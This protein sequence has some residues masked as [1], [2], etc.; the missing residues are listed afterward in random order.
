MRL[1]QNKLHKQ[2]NCEHTMKAFTLRWQGKPVVRASLITTSAC[3]RIELWLTR[4]ADLVG[5]GPHQ[6]LVLSCD[7][8]MGVEKR[9]AQY[10]SPA[11][12]PTSHESLVVVALDRGHSRVA[13]S[14]RLT[15]EGGYPGR[16]KL[17]F[18]SSHGARTH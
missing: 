8:R 1:R 3:R 7:V 9:S 11:T 5:G 17:F 10:I 14:T 2:Q 16:C 12:V 18:R 4:P 6:F 15:S 13:E